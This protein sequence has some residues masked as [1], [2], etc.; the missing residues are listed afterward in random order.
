MYS[1]YSKEAEVLRISE[2]KKFFEQNIR[3]IH[4]HIHYDESVQKRVAEQFR[5]EPS[6]Y[7]LNRISCLFFSKDSKFIIDELNNMCVNSMLGNFFK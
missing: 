1:Y 2:E 4:R 7:N 5:I 3:K 6:P